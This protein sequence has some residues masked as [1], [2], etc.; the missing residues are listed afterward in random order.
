[1][2]AKP[3]L[4]PWSQAEELL[5]RILAEV[6]LLDVKHPRKRHLPSARARILRVID[7]L[8]LLAVA[9][10]IVFDHNP[11][12]PQ[13]REYPWGSLVQVFAQRILQPADLD[14]AVEFRHTDVGAEAPDRLR[15]VTATPQPGDRRHA[16]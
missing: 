5:G 10:G 2:V 4:A 7:G 16:R 13:D 11:Q 12:R 9:L 15:G 14:S 1:G 3:H 8:Q 6:I